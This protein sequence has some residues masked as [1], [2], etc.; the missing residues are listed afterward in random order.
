MNGAGFAPGAPVLWSLYCPEPP[1]WLL[2]MAGAPA[3]RR[4]RQVGMNCGCEYPGFAVYRGATP[5]SRFEHSVGTALLLWQMTHDERISAA[6]LFHDLSTPVFAH[7]VDFLNGDYLEQE[8]TEAGILPL[9]EQDAVLCAGLAALGLRPADVQDYHMFCLADSPSPRLCADRLEYT[10]GNLLHFGFLSFEELA[11]LRRE[12]TVAEN[13]D[14]LP[15]PAF[16]SPEAARC[17][18]LGALRCSR[19]YVS[20]EDRWAMQTLAGLLRDALAA[21]VLQRSQ[22]AATEPEV[23]ARL[24]ADPV[25]AGRWRL[26]TRVDTVTAVRS[27]ERPSPQAVRVQAKLRY[28]DP[29]AAGR[30]RASQLFPQFGAELRAFAHTDLSDWL[31][32]ACSSGA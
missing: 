7:T 18:A 21:G 15:E 26:F 27:A 12:L 29:L 30:G 32:G 22:L 13:E 14:G 25:F 9:I 4:L 17:F 5:Y 11:G 2:S 23:I 16:S 24:C 28:I 1:A 8:S 31:T 19:L 10:F 3:L 20:N 6:G